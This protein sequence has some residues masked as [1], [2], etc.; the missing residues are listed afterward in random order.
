VSATYPYQIFFQADPELNEALQF[1]E[2]N[3]RPRKTRSAICR[4]AVYEFL[5]REC[6]DAFKKP[7]AIAAE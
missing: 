7:D 2:A 5:I 3:L 1:G 6:P 4:Q